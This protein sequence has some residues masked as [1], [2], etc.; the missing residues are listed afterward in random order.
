MR[1]APRRRKS[2]RSRHLDD[3][4]MEGRD[5]LYYPHDALEEVVSRVHR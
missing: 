3:L 4:K 1:A 2:L 5:L